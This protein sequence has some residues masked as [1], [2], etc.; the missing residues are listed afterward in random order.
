M[1]APLW[2]GQQTG[3]TKISR[4]AA[5]TKMLPKTFLLRWVSLQEPHCRHFLI[6]FETRCPQQRHKL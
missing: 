4:M 1:N 6:V 3:T 2:L 5:M